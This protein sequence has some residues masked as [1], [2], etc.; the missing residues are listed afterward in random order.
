[1]FGVKSPA[2]VVRRGPL[3]PDASSGVSCACSRCVCLR[4][5]CVVEASSRSFLGAAGVLGTGPAAG[6]QTRAERGL[7]GPGE[8]SMFEPNPEAIAPRRVS[9]G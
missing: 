8:E 5:Q 4:E 3:R 2:F 9:L 7:G 6:L 1:M